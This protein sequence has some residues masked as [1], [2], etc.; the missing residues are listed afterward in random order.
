MF[1]ILVFSACDEEEN[2][3]TQNEEIVEVVEKITFTRKTN[4]DFAATRIDTMRY[5]I[6]S[7]NVYSFWLLPDN[8]FEEGVIGKPTTIRKTFSNTFMNILD[9]FDETE[10]DYFFNSDSIKYLP[11]IGV[12]SIG[13]FYSVKIET[14][15]RNHKITYLRKNVSTRFN[16]FLILSKTYIN[17]NDY[18][19]LMKDTLIR[20]FY[21]E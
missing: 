11:S 12:D 13:E 4:E 8:P 5:N 16:D 19:D 6:D 10:L 21:D 9:F 20:E 7:L 17:Y 2:K 18:W 15:K 3:I 14:T 1:T